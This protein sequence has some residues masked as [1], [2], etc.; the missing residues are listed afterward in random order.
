MIGYA[1]VSTADQTL[2]LQLDA[3]KAVGCERI[4]QEKAS[5]AADARPKLDACL[6]V[7]KRGDVL[8]VWKLDRLGRTTRKLIELVDDL[9][10][11]GVEFRSTTDSIDTSTPMGRF[12]FRIMSALCEMERDL[13]RERTMAGMASAKAR[14]RNGGRPKTMTRAQAE[15]AR[16]LLA[17]GGTIR[18]V[19]AGLGLSPATMMR[20]LQMG[21]WAPRLPAGAADPCT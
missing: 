6:A 2:D 21:Q 20:T 19:A 18:G 7:L 10:T 17:D 3:L 1:R 13:I 16:K 9:A 14:G 12:F 8:V 4:F 5:G 11:A 15:M